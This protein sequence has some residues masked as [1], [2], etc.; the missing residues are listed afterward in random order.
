MSREKFDFEDFKKFIPV[1]R[2]TEDKLKCYA[3]LL[4]KWNKAI[5]LVG[6]DTIPDLW[7]RHFLDSAQLVKYIPEFS[8]EQNNSKPVIID[9]GSGA[10][11]PAII[12]AI[13]GVGEVHA[14]ESD[15]KKSTFLREVS[16][17][18]N[19]PL[20]VHNQRIEKITPFAAN[21]FTAR[22]F[23]SLDKIIEFAQPFIEVS[24]RDTPPE[25]LLLKGRSVDQE[26]T[27]AEKKWS[28]N[29]SRYT[30]LSDSEATILRLKL[31]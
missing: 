26:L 29:L 10:G 18:T 2:E 15:I 30:S 16:R 31:L 4:V 9:F 19:T 7:R 12:L 11:F 5:N 28:M 3:E 27:E 17:E 13:L 8:G 1:S 23:A 22:A 24:S 6:R 21:Y 14:M 20:T 25:F